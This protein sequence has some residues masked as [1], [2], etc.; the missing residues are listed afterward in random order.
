MATA[1]ANAHAVAILFVIVHTRQQ[2][3]TFSL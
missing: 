1:S 3:G 2:R